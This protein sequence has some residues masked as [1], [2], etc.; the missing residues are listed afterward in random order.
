[1]HA[2]RAP[3]ATGSDQSDE[4]ARC[5]QSIHRTSQSTR[6]RRGVPRRPSGSAQR[7]PDDGRSRRVLRAGPGPS[8]GERGYRDGCAAQRSDR[9]IRPPG[10]ARENSRSLALGRAEVARCRGPRAPDMLD[11][12]PAARV[13]GRARISRATPVANWR[14]A[15]HEESPRCSAAASRATGS[16]AA[17]AAGTRLRR[18]ARE[19]GGRLSSRR[20]RSFPLWSDPGASVGSSGGCG[21]VW[22]CGAPLGGWRPCLVHRR[23]NRYP[24]PAA[25]FVWS[26]RRTR[27]D[28]LRC[29]RG[30]RAA[31]RAGFSGS[32]VK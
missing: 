22:D 23:R 15:R 30:A 24:Q 14:L 27:L 28:R 17:V 10:S 1:M 29:R 11:G 19:P 7:S 9:R 20:G 8:G 12:A 21:A 2:A 5:V 6:L 4:P 25:G 16:R 13:P 32:L 26:R 31:C 3:S 18:S